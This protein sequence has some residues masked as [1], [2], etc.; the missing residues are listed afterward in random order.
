MSSCFKATYKSLCVAPGGVGSDV[1]PPC[2]YLT[3][4]EVGGWSIDWVREESGREM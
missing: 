2:A 1:V 4:G 3:V